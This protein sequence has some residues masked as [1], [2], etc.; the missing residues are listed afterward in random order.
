V[1]AARER[2]RFDFESQQSARELGDAVDDDGAFGL[3]SVESCLGARRGLDR[4]TR[5]QVAERRAGAHQDEHRHGRAGEHAP[6]R[7]RA[8]PAGGH[9]TCSD[10]DESQT[11]PP[12]LCGA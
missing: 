9:R 2:G 11:V 7:K 12:G 6:R 10:N 1:Q 3:R 8:H 4:I 5:E